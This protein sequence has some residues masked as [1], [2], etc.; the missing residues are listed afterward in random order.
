MKIVFFGNIKDNESPTLDEDILY[1]LKKLGHDVVE[2]D[3]K[4]VDLDGLSKEEG[5]LLLFRNGGVV[6]DDSLNFQLSL[7]R[8][9]NIL[10]STKCKKKAMWFLDPVIGTGN[11]FLNI[12]IPMVDYAFL[13]DDTF[14]RRNTFTN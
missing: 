12:I 9:V 10:Q 11:D 6:T 2:F 13:N 8:L 3:T 14:I 7:T 5:D 1:A 4:E